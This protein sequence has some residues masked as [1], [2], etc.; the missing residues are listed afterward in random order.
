MQRA[1]YIAGTAGCP[2]Y[3]VHTSSA[4]ALE[5]ALRLRRSGRTVHVETCPHYLTHDV[6]WSGGDVGK[7]NPPLREAVRP[8]GA[9]A[10]RF[11]TAVSTRSRPT[12]SI[13]TSSSKAGGI[14][15]A[16]PGC[17]GLETLLPVMLSEGH[18]ARG[19]SLAR[20]AELVATNPARI[21]GLAPQGRDRGRPRRGLRP[22]R[23]ERHDRDL[24]GADD[25][26]CGL[27]DLRRMEAQGPRRAHAC[28]RRVCDA[29][30]RARRCLYRPRP[31]YPA[32]ADGSHLD[33][34]LHR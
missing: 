4:E 27:L 11:A 29:R 34:L 10:R 8:R 19:I 21:M 31:L 12:T 15:T 13:A 6:A 25:Q 26:Q 2:L 5:A 9:L 32:P 17:P 24:L 3:V 1:A 18:H 33:L 28:A 23:P 22:G 30:R 7:I 16:S 20:I 14:W